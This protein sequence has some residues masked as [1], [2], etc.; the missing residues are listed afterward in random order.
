MWAGS[1][2]EFAEV[3]DTLVK[4]AIE[5]HNDLSKNKNSL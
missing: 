2:L 4:L 5:R 1:G 3:I